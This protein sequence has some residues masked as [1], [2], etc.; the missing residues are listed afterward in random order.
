ML[1]VM[2]TGILLSQSFRVLIVTISVGLM[3]LV[4]AKGAVV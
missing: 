2:E 1:F 3:Y 4:N